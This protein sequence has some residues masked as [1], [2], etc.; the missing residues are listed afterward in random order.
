MMKKSKCARDA[1]MNVLRRMIKKEVK[2][3][4][5]PSL[6]IPSTVKSLQDFQW[7]RVIQEASHSI[8]LLTGLL[9]GSLSC[10]WNKNADM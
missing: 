7:Q 8:P 3:A 9:Q 2:N 4:N 10:R 5:I 1:V 6:K